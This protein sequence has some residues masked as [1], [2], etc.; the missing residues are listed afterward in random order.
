MLIFETYY[1]SY[2][3]ILSPEDF[4]Q[5]WFQWNEVVII[6]E[7]Q[8]ERTWYFTPETKIRDFMTV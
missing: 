7:I 3:W 6:Q 2:D 5:W 4:K 8:S 1:L